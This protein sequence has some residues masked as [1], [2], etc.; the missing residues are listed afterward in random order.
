MNKTIAIA[1]IAVSMMLL[2][3]SNSFAVPPTK[4]FVAP[5]D[6]DQMVGPV[7][8]NSHGL[9]K[10]QLNDEGQIEYQILVSDIPDFTSA[11]I[12]HGTSDVNGAVMVHLF[13]SPPTH[14]HGLIGQGTITD[15]DVSL[16]DI[17]TVAELLEQMENG[18]A[19]V[20]IRTEIYPAGIIR[21]QI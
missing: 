8:T 4:N 20:V 12:H 1:S 21:G 9:A 15:G 6:G 11:K 10:F 16:G 3:S 13:D 14:V 17:D 7:D 2:G 5:M 19:Y 18:E